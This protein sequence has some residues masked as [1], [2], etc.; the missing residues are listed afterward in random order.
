MFLNIKNVK[1]SNITQT[2]QQS[3]EVYIEG[4]EVDDILVHIDIAAAIEYY[5]ITELLDTIGE[6]NLKSHLESLNQDV[7]CSSGR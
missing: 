3:L 6:E 2:S 5:G 7:E 4:V 1:N